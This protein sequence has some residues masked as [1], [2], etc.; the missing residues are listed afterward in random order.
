MRVSPSVPVH[1]AHSNDLMVTLDLA[2]VTI[3]LL[4]LLHAWP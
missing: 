1:L 3:A 4:V 2:G